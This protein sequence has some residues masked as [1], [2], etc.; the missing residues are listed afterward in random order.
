MGISLLTRH[1]LADRFLWLLLMSRM[2]LGCIFCF[3][4]FRYTRRGYS[5]SSGWYHIIC[6]RDCRLDRWVG[7]RLFETAPCFYPR[8][9]Y[10]R[11]LSSE[12]STMQIMQCHCAQFPCS[13]WLR[14]QPF[15]HRVHSV[16][17]ARKLKNNKRL[18]T[19]LNMKT[20][21]DGIAK[22]ASPDDNAI[23]HRSSDV[24]MNA[25]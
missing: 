7:Y 1:F 2:R 9:K 14:Q 21:R 15:W 24:N 23:T 20:A 10:E 22:A 5:T 17:L 11:G 25:H 18:L 6:R 19:N 13:N 12:L 16:F 3:T 4:L 8:P